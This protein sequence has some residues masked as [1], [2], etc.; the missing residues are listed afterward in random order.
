MKEKIKCDFFSADGLSLLDQ[1]IEF[2]PR[3][4][5]QRIFCRPATLHPPP[6]NDMRPIYAKRDYELTRFDGQKAEYR[7]VVE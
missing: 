2:P 7:E 5:L 4:I 3:R 1:E 6:E